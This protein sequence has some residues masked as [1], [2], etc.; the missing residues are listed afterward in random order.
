MVFSNSVAIEYRKDVNEVEKEIISKTLK[1]CLY[2]HFRYHFKIVNCDERIDKIKKILCLKDKDDS[3]DKT[4]RDTITYCLGQTFYIESL[5]VNNNMFCIL[6]GINY[7]NDVEFLYDNGI[8][9]IKVL[10]KSEMINKKY[11][12]NFDIYKN[13]YFF[14]IIIDDTENNNNNDKKKSMFIQITNF[15]IKIK[16]TD[17]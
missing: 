10:K 4:V 1:E 5:F 11:I 16:R 6:N 15:C 12:S 17:F 2:S 8:I 9:I 13:K 14:F 3:V 7:R